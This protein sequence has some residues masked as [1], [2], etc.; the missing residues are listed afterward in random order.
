M[1]QYVPVKFCRRYLTGYN[2]RAK[3]VL[4]TSH[5]GRWGEV[6]CMVFEYFGKLCGQNWKKFSD[7]NRLGVGDVCEFELISAVEKVMKVTISKA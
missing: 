2:K 5:G 1:L 3:C 6:D 7:E 4:E